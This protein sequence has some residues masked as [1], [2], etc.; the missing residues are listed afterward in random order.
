[1]QKSRAKRSRR[2]WS[3][4]DHAIRNPHLVLP[5]GDRRAPSPPL[6]ISEPAAR[7]RP[8]SVDDLAV[9]PLADYIPGAVPSKIYEAMA[10]RVPVVSTTV[11]AEGL[12][13]NPPH[14]IRIAD[15]PEDFG[16]CCLELLGN[17]AERTRVSSA[18]WELVSSSFSWEQ[19]SRRF[20]KIME[21]GPRITGT[22]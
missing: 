10:A 8:R 12:T 11:G 1:M 19:V 3:L 14:D 5:A 13:V 16:Q 18:A 21:S 17:S 20:E 9:V 6:R 7:T 22:V 4:L 2:L 15:Q